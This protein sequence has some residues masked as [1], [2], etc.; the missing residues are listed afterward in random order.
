MKKKEN[1]V[2]KEKASVK[3]DRINVIKQKEIAKIS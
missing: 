3:L 1:T 2:T